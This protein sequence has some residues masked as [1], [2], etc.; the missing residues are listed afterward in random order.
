[1]PPKVSLVVRSPLPNAVVGTQPFTV[2]G[3]ATAPAGT[4]PVE[5]HSVTVQVDAQPIVKAALVRIPNPHLIE[6]TFSATVLITGGQDPHTVTV[7]VL[8]DDLP[9]HSAV[10]V[11]AGPRVV[12]PALLVDLATLGTVDTSSKMVQSLLQSLAQQAAA[13]PLVDQLGG[14]NKLFVGPNAV[15]VSDPRPLLR[16]GFWILDADFPAAELLSPSKDFPLRRLTDAAASGSFALAPLLDPPP[17]NTIDPATDPMFG[18]AL[19]VPIDTLQRVLDANFAD[20]ATQA[21]S[22]DFTLESATVATDSS[23][24]VT[25]TF[26]GSLPLGL[27][28]TASLTETVGIAQ[29]PGTDQS[30]PVVRSSSSSVSVPAVWFIAS[31]V[32]V[33]G[34][35]VAG[36]FDLAAYGV[37]QAS[38]QA[39][40]ILTGLLAQLPSIVPFRSSELPTKA[41]IPDL[42]YDPASKYPF[43][44]AVVNFES[45]TTDGSG[46]VGTGTVGL[47]ERDQS[48]V[49]VTVTG[50]SYF[51]N[52]STGVESFYTVLLG[53][54]EPD[55]DQMTW[56]VT[57]A[58]KPGTVDID[59]FFQQGGFPTGFSLPSKPS[60]GKY[61]FTISVSGTETCATDA[62]KSLTGSTSLAVTVNVVKGGH[63]L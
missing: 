50:P 55:D 49:G 20:F 13:L 47:G 33:V 60:P 38:G 15:V 12:A 54:F 2:S 24:S 30:M 58:T 42:P 52:Y 39:N 25:V 48:M 32:P 62:T 45:F 43:P 51:P 5:I 56:T 26:S 27:D 19:S 35:L 16:I 6:V 59:P 40:G 28:L 11:T 46:L 31:F 61:H 3:L 17:P 41:D 36:A 22:N 9:V 14:I 37:G 23:G 29:R 7:T 10:T 63:P 4:E 57:G 18:F 1:M 8:S 21:A 34:L 44:M 53:Y